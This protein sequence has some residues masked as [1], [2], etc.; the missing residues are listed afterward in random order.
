MKDSEIL[1][2]LEHLNK[3]L[4]T[5][6]ML[7]AETKNMSYWVGGAILGIIIILMWKNIL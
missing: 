3:R 7:C 2:K 6:A 1:E 5:I 4:N